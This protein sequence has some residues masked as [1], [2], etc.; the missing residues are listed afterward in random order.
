[1]RRRAKLRRWKKLIFFGSKWP[2]FCSKSLWEKKKT[3]AWASLG[4][5][6]L[7][8]LSWKTAALRLLR[9]L[10][11]ETHAWLWTG[12][13]LHCNFVRL[14]QALMS[15]T[16]FTYDY[17][18][19]AWRLSDTWIKLS[20]WLT[21][22]LTASQKIGTLRNLGSPSSSP[23]DSKAECR[24][25]ARIVCKIWSKR[26]NISEAAWGVCDSEDF[27][28]F[29]KFWQIFLTVRGPQN[30]QQKL[31]LQIKKNPAPHEMEEEEEKI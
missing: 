1:M 9:N 17:C 31:I 18:G 4:P 30:N 21:N 11:R 14:V 13:S 5:R 22:S 28:I 12:S 20:S 3:T 26:R 27:T 24:S 19:T 8:Y 25:H 23:I 6:L 2:E 7:R 15:E 29:I 16:W 10:G